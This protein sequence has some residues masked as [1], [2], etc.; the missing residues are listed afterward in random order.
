[1]K[2]Q[3][4]NMSWLINLFVFFTVLFNKDNLLNF[5]CHSFINYLK[6]LKNLKQFNQMYRII[7]YTK[8]ECG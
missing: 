7:C 6:E 3:T 1:M 2:I 8:R 5:D 4:T